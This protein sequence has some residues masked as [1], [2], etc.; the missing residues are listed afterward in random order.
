M[1]IGF[2]NG[3]IYIEFFPKITKVPAMVIEG[4]KVIFTGKNE[5]AGK[6]SGKII[7]LKGSTVLPGFIDAHMHLDETGIYLNNLDL[8]ETKSIKELKEKLRSFSEKT[9]EPIIGWGW[10]QELF[11]ERRWPEKKDIDDIVNNRPVFLSR[12]DGHSAL[13]NSYFLSVIKKESEN[14]ILMEADLNYARNMLNKIITNETKSKYIA[15]AVNYLAK[16]GVTSVGFVSCS[17]E[18]FEILKKMDGI[19]RLY[20]RV[21]VYITSDDFDNIIDFKDTE[22]LKFKGIKLFSDGSLGSRTALLSNKYNDYDTYGEQA[23]PLHTLKIYSKKCED[24]RKQV[25]IHAIGD[26]GMD[27]AMASLKDLEPGNRIEHCSVIRDDQLEKLGGLNMVVQP[28]FIHSDFWALERL[29]IK[30]AHW[31]YRFKDMLNKGL[32]VAFSTDSP[33]E[34]INPFLGVYSA[35]TRGK[36][37]N[38]PLSKYTRDQE[39]TIE[40]SLHCYTKG[41]AFAIQEMNIGSL[42]EGNYADF[43]VV[44]R[45]PIKSGKRKI[46]EIKV[47]ET[48]VGG[49]KIFG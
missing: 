13:V 48:Y 28:H 37:E 34:Q 45:N 27:I 23:M 19:G 35:V 26:A 4:Q 29:G 38:I 40:E 41:S 3:E 30:R 11:E 16:Y 42:R 17:K 31:I 39:L 10:D 15:D 12:V 24:R 6:I 20:I 1:R 49:K 5:I 2:L 22:H 18:I 14:G 25:A 9:T 8:R 21:Y 43:I 33:V 47:K 32:N 44:D 46:K 36:Y 7:D